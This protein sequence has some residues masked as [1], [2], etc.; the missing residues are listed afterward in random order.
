MTI[1]TNGKKKSRRQLIFQF[2]LLIL[3]IIIIIFLSVLL[4][5]FGANPLI[6]ILILVFVFLI[7]LGPLLKR[8]QKSIYASLFPDKKKVREE[9]I[10]KKEEEIKRREEMK[11]FKLRHLNKIDLDFEYREPIIRK[12]DNCGLMIPKFAKKCP[13]CGK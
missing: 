3:N 1:Q 10:Q 5:E 13:I 9:K 6:I 7:F 4:T 2:F 8:R 12:C 11:L